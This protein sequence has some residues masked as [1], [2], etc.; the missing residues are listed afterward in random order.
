MVGRRVAVLRYAIYMPRALAR[1]AESDL[2]TLPWVGFDDRIAYT[3]VAQ[4]FRAAFP[5]VTPRLRADSLPAMLHAAAAGVGAVVLPMFAAAGEPRLVRVTPPIAGPEMGLWLLHHPDVRG[6]ARVRALTQWLADAVPAEIE[7]LAAAG[8]TSARLRD[9]PAVP[10]RRTRP[11][12]RVSSQVL[13][14]FP[15]PKASADLERL[16]RHVDRQAEVQ[17]AGLLPSPFPPWQPSTFVTTVLQLLR[18]VD[19]RGDRR[20]LVLPHAQVEAGGSDSSAQ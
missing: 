19:G 17:A 13:R 8:P 20:V 2:G 15:C 9:C 4:W 10:R 5:G 1:R 11:P 18:M 16:A 3:E 7:R 6:N 12:D 14:R